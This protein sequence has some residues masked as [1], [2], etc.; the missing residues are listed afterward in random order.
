MVFT[1]NKVSNVAV[2]TR[3]SFSTLPVRQA[4]VKLP[5]VDLTVNPFVFA[6]DVARFALL[7]TAYV[8][9]S[10]FHIGCAFARATPLT[11]K[12]SKPG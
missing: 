4:I 7:H 1:I 6:L 8:N 11:V 5:L 9:I 3:V 10:V 2:A 12:L